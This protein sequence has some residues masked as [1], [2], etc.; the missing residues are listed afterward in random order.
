MR[1][2]T[3]AV[4]GLIVAGSLATT[5]LAFDAREVVDAAKVMADLRNAVGGADKVAA[6]RTLTAEGLQRRLA[7]KGTT[8]GPIDLAIELPDK[9]ST[10]TALTNLGSM[11]TFLTTGFNGDGLVY[12]LDAPPN[13]S[14]PVA[15]KKAAL[16]KAGGQDPK[17]ADVQ[18]ADATQNAVLTAKQEFARLALGWLG[19]SYET[20][21]LQFSYVAEAESVDGT[22]H[23]IE[24]RGAGSFSVRLFVDTGTS[25]PLMMRWTQLYPAGKG[26]PAKEVVH[27]VYYS[28]FRKTGALTLPHRFQRSMGTNPTEEI[29]FEK[30]TINGPVDQ[31]RFAISK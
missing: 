9:F 21:P 4:F 17:A 5:G 27:S 2:V 29:T 22:A 20:F 8:E 19:S 15:K 25:L 26:G 10:R 30:I 1:N 23:V 11:S 12:D 3:I 6:V 24:A 13:L 16:L 7:A 28:D 31:K 14:A 18:E